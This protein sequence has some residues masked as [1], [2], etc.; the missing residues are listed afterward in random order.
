ML[1]PT[2]RID[3][4][5]LPRFSAIVGERNALTDASDIAPYVSEERELYQGL[6]NLRTEGTR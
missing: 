6:K 1:N 3:P 2:P 5:L 4:A